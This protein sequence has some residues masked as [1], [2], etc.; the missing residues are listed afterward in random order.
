MPV[1]DHSQ[2]HTEEERNQI[3][4]WA[5]DLLGQK[6]SDGVHQCFIRASKCNSL[7]LHGRFFMIITESETYW[8]NEVIR[9]E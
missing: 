4:Q 2:G 3:S 1:G 6:L 5:K 9:A 7:N 8:K